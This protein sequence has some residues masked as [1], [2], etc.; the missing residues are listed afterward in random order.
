MTTL[1]VIITLYVLY[2]LICAIS[3]RRQGREAQRL[4]FAASLARQEQR[5]ALARYN[6]YTRQQAALRCEQ[7]RQRKQAEWDAV[8]RQRQEDAA[9]RAGQRLE[10][11]ERELEHYRPLLEA[12]ERQAEELRFYVWKLEKHGLSCS[13]KKAE[14]ER[15]QEKIYRIET[16][17]LKAEQAKELCERRIA[18]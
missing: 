12:L 18:G 9:F 11:A 2:K 1:L 17:L 14:L 4:R 5:E 13:A 3:A 15:V 6:E 16:R 10:L 8:L 7:E